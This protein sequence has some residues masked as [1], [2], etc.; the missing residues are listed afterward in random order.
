MK[1]NIMSLLRTETKL[2]NLNYIL[3]SGIKF[4]S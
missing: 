3:V 2:Y 1:Y 4:I